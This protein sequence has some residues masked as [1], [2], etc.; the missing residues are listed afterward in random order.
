M[1]EQ[2]FER[3]A[4]VKA[5]R[6][7]SPSLD[8]RRGDVVLGVYEVRDIL[9][10]GGMGNVFR[11]WHR[12]WNTEIAVKVPKKDGLLGR[13]GY[14]IFEKEC[15]LQCCVSNNIFCTVIYPEHK[16]GK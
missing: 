10:E 11:V 5:Q 6:A 15:E 2:G 14:A 13:A 4:S 8:W 3:F 12:G 1:P 16:S 7:P 9:G